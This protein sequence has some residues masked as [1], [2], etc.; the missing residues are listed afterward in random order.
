MQAVKCDIALASEG[1]EL[2]GRPPISA[3][4]G[5]GENQSDGRLDLGGGS[6]T[7]GERT[8]IGAFVAEA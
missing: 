7:E 5:R 2:L 6:K 8:V 4:A 1:D 3:S